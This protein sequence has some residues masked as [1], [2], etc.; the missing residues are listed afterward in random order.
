MFIKQIDQIL[1]LIFYVWYV[2]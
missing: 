1:F 2:K